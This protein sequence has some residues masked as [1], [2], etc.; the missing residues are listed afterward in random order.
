MKCK[1][2]ILLDDSKPHIEKY[3][4]Q[5]EWEP[6]TLVDDDSLE[7][8]RKNGKG[9]QVEQTQVTTVSKETE[10][11]HKRSR[12]GDCFIAETI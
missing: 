8:Q 4:N 2:P 3:A 10:N 6:N 11:V 9:K 5:L 12:E 7:M 1:L